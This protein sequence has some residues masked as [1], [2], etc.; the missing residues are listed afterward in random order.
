MGEA[1]ISL[2]LGMA[3]LLVLCVI[4]AIEIFREQVRLM[5]ARAIDGVVLFADNERI[6][7]ALDGHAEI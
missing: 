2:L 1:C 4:L 6:G 5:R 7:Q 3:G